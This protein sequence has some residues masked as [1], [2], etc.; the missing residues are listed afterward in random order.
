MNLHSFVKLIP[1]LQN[2]DEWYQITHIK[3]QP[4]VKRYKVSRSTGEFYVSAMEI[5]EVK[6]EEE[7]SDRMEVV[8]SG[9]SI[10][11]ANGWD[12]CGDH[13][14]VFYEF[15]PH[16]ETILPSAC[17]DESLYVNFEH[18]YLYTTNDNGED[19]VRLDMVETLAKI[20]RKS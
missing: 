13:E 1:A 10:G 18:G 7:M 15:K 14:L 19:I 6:S 12:E 9:R 20:P 16:A 11:T 3:P 2:G 5:S 8:V 4:T 17:A